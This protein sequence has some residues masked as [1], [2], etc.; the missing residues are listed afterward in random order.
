[1]ATNRLLIVEDDHAV[2]QLIE[3]VARNAGYQVATTSTL[4]DFLSHLDNDFPTHIVLDLNMPS[5]DGIEF[6]RILAER[7]STAKIVITSGVG[8]RVLDA[9]R[10]LGQDRGLN[11]VATLPKPFRLA[12]A[13][14]LMAGL[15][16]TESAITH[17]ALEAAIAQGDLFLVYQP[18]VDLRTGEVAGYEALVRWQHAVHGIVAPDQFLPLA[19]SSELIHPLTDTVFRL[20]LRQLAAWR[21]QPDATLALNVS[22][23][24]LFD[25]TFADRLHDSCAL[26]GIEP[27]RLVLELTE[28]SA[29]ADPVNAMDILSRLRI[30]GFR[31]SLDDFGTG[32]S[33][34]LQLARLPF[35]ELKVDRTFVQEMRSSREARA[36]VKSIVELAHN[37]GLEST[38]EG[39]EDAEAVK[40]L[41]DFGCDLAQGYFLAKPMPAEQIVDWLRF[42]ERRRGDIF[43]SSDQKPTSKSAAMP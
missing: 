21:D 33:S 29:M 27:R 6:M 2:A 35:S 41:I 1:M 20:G 38:A 25:L 12:E 16:N 31:L 28:T 23:R 13:S 34:L 36:I 30:K 43:P 24:C 8:G 39:I 5:V 17:E 22:G 14:Q 40:S 9:A 10:R 15:L 19:E 26:A 42:W 18:K 37:L 4:D 11:V 32:Y 3:T 7:K